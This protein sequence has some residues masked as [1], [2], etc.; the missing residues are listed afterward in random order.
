M[1]I[2]EKFKQ[3]MQRAAAKKAASI[4]IE[5]KETTV[6]ASDEDPTMQ[7]DESPETM[8]PVEDVEV[9]KK[10]PVVL[11]SESHLMRTLSSDLTKNPKDRVSVRKFLPKIQKIVGDRVRAIETYQK[12]VDDV[13]EFQKAKAGMTEEEIAN[14]QEQ[15]SKGPPV[16]S[17]DASAQIFI[18]S[19]SMLA[20]LCMLPP[21]GDGSPVNE[22]LI[23]SA[24]EEKKISHGVDHSQITKVVSEELYYQVVAIARGQLPA[25]G[26][27]GKITDRYSRTQDIHLIEDEKGIINYKELNI[28]QA[29]EAGDIICDLLWP[30]DSEIGYNVLGRELPAQDGKMPPIP[31]GK[32]TEVNEDQTALIATING[33][34]SFQKGCFRVQVQLIIPND[35]D[36][37]TGNINFDGDV[38]VMGDVLNGFQVEATGNV[39]VSGMATSAIIT[40]GEDID[41]KKGVNGGISGQLKA[42]GD[43]SS[44]YLEQ[45]K[46]TAQGN[47]ISEAIINCQII[48]AGNIQ[49]ISGRGSIVGGTLITTHSIEAKKIGNL[50]NTK[51]I[52]KIGQAVS[53]DDYEDS[54][55]EEL[56]TYQETYEKIE[57]NVKYLS[58]L[59]TLPEQK[60][61]LL[62]VLKE[63]ASLYRMR[64][65]E[66]HN[67]LEEMVLSRPDCKECYVRGN[68]IYGITEITMSSYTLTIR[69]S[70]SQCNVYYDDEDEELVTG[71][72]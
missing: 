68:V 45:I 37:S 35:V 55:N 49:A 4:I 22:E 48:C 31:K 23:Y 58:S 63:Q 18:T 21:V 12:W 30:T 13:D 33:D 10:P 69:D 8:E 61:D 11:N 41:V 54:I 19:D 14:H 50:S 29:V 65:A 5:E 36:G 53:G 2:Y 38:L 1:S 40:A 28:L 60:S 39:L 34:L 66:L 16:S 51:T 44:R 64:L 46:I 42:G 25:N 62:I 17:A 71:T 70:I 24:L 15:F 27:P 47:I 3:R 43:V 6:P 9:I 56:T 52:L 72:Y 59:P 32:N 67:K 7:T 57:K 26:R 20:Y